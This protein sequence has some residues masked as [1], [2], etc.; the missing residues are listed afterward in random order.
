MGRVRVAIA[1]CLAAACGDSH[2]AKPAD[3]AYDVPWDGPCGGGCDAPID[4]NPLDDLMGTGL[5]A[6]KACTTINAGIAAY[7]PRYALW[8]DAA[9]KRRWIY[10]PPGTQIDTTDP[11][12][13][14]F[15]TGTKIWKEFT[16][17]ST[18][19]ETRF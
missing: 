7:T 6:D 16:S 1:L 5:C 8:A 3:A 4:A 17:G 10:L 2:T 18:R 15:P 13:W 11:D 12:H 19:V 14:L 9:S